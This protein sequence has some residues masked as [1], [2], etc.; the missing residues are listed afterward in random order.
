M[1]DEWEI[2]NGLRFDVKDNK[3]DADNDGL[4]NSEEFG[5]GTDPHSA[6]SDG[7]EIEDYV[8]VREIKTDP[9]KKNKVIWPFIVLPVLILLLLHISYSCKV[10][11]NKQYHPHIDYQV[12]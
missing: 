4:L 5:L 2:M 12:L 9:L 1:P 6:D 3:K 10:L 7:D 8:E 11:Y